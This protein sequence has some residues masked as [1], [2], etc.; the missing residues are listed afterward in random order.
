[1]MESSVD[2]LRP[3]AFLSLGCLLLL[4]LLI[5][6][7]F[8][9]KVFEQMDTEL[10]SYFEKRFV[11]LRKISLVLLLAFPLIVGLLTAVLPHRFKLGVCSVGIVIALS[12]SFFF[13]E[14]KTYLKSI[15]REQKVRSEKREG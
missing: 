6:K 9:K 4:Q 14:V 7:T 5:R 10:L 8:P 13:F 12:A 3:V 11:F 2:V 15:W 1:M